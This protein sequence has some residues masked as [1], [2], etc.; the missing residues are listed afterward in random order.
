MET[1]TPASQRRAAT[2]ISVED[3]DGDDYDDYEF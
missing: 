2:L 3:D 1:T